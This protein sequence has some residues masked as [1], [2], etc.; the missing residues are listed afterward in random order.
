MKYPLLIWG[1]YFSVLWCSDRKWGA[2]S[3]GSSP[4]RSFTL[5]PSGSNNS[6][7]LV[8]TNDSW[9]WKHPMACMEQAGWF[10]PNIHWKI[11]KSHT[12]LSQI[13]CST[14][15]PLTFL[16]VKARIKNLPSCDREFS[17][18]FRISFETRQH[19]EADLAAAASACSVNPCQLPGT[20]RLSP[21]LQLTEHQMYTVHFTSSRAG[22]SHLQQHRHEAVFSIWSKHPFLLV[23]SPQTTWLYLAGVF[24]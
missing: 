22:A 6:H 14:E 9:P 13:R 1:L 4:W 18:R 17:P 7:C 15:T 20:A 10:Q 5:N 8:V 2:K 21:A 12:L 23:R 16:V 3:T 24:H 11:N 19:M